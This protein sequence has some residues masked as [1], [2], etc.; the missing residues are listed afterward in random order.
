MAC[1]PGDHGGVDGA[2][3][4]RPVDAVGRVG[5]QLGEPQE[6]LGGDLA[7]LRVVLADP[8]RVGTCGVDD[9]QDVLRGL[10]PSGR[11]HQPFR[12]QHGKRHDKAA[13]WRSI[14]SG[15]IPKSNQ[16]GRSGRE[17]DEVS[18]EFMIGADNGAF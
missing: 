11:R 15:I 12:K 1:Q 17:T 14:H 10:R 9:D 16:D 6:L 2:I 5:R 13:N 3:E 4:D 8:H 18:A 7:L